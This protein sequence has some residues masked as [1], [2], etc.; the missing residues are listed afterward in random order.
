M[1][2][3]TQYRFKYEEI[4]KYLKNH[5][6]SKIAFCK[7]CNISMHTLNKL[8]KGSV[9]INAFASFRVSEILKLNLSDLVAEID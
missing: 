4:I 6:M 1:Q 7:L 2:Q 9:M 3:L 8:L 5:N